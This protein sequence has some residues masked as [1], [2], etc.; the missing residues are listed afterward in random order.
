MLAAPKA[1]ALGRCI[2][3]LALALL[4][5]PAHPQLAEAAAQA[6]L[7]IHAAGRARG[8]DQG[9]GQGQGASGGPLTAAVLQGLM[10]FLLCEA[11]AT[12][13]GA[14]VGGGG[15]VGRGSGR[16]AALKARSL[17]LPIPALFL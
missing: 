6:L 9:Q 1:E 15:G 16:A 3:A 4:A 8:A 14:G 7:A 12:V 17:P 5:A 2:D 13:G 10:P 11:K